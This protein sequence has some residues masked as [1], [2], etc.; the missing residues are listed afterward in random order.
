MPRTHRP[1]HPGYSP[2]VAELL[3]QHC[4]HPCVEYQASRDFR[5]PVS[6][7]R[8]GSLIQIQQ[9]PQPLFVEY[10]SPQNILETGSIVALYPA[11]FAMRMKLTKPSFMAPPITHLKY[12]TES[13]AMTT[14]VRFEEVRP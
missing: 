2:T 13:Q 5:W 12:Q 6:S 8:Q 9:I 4:G 11:H 7:R 1:L 10:E 3:H 14:T